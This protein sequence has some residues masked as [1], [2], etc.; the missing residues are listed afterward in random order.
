MALGLDSEMVKT[1]LRIN[2]IN[3]GLSFPLGLKFML[4]NTCQYIR[5][6]DI[7]VVAAEYLSF[8]EDHYLGNGQYLQQLV[9]DVD[10][11]KIRLLTFGQIITMAKYIPNLISIKFKDLNTP[12]IGEVNMVYHRNAFNEYGDVY[13]HWDL[14]NREFDE[15]ESINIEKYNH[16]AM[17]KLKEFEETIHKKGAML[18]ISYPPYQD[19]SFDLSI[20]SIKKIEE[21]FIKQ[22]FTVLGTPERYRMDNS[23]MFDSPYHLNRNGTV[24]RTELLIEDLR[25][26]GVGHK[27]QSPDHY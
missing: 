26:A 11:T 8:Y 4:D 22:G 25:E 15:Q 24:L 21:E 14:E 6:S 1:S 9:W 5:E 20:E 3:N 27:L 23:L 18:F 13:S 17:K 2:P 12:N 19:I 10:K 7:V 16:K